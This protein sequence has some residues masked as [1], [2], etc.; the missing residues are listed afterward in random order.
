MRYLDFPPSLHKTNFNE[1]VEVTEGLPINLTVQVLSSLPLTSEPVWSRMNGVLSSSSIVINF[2][3]DKMNFTSLGL[4]NVSHTND[5]GIYS[6]TASNR[7]GSSSFI[8]YIS[9][10]GNYVF[11]TYKNYVN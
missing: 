4:Y 10:K 11:D 3:R 9:V 8:V 5:T 2:I 7:C 1:V 6:L